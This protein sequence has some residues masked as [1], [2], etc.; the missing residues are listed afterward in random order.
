MLT[1]RA[2]MMDIPKDRMSGKRRASFILFSRGRTYR[3]ISVRIEEEK[4]EHKHK[5]K[6]HA[7]S[8]GIYTK[9]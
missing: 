8:E 4:K 1:Y 2:V 7:T 3:N 6:R 5:E 9:E